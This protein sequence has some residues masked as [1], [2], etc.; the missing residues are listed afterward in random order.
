DV[1]GG[2]GRLRCSHGGS[3]GGSGGLLVQPLADDGDGL[4]R[5]PLGE[6]THFLHRLR[7]HL[8]LHLR[9]V[10]HLAGGA[11][12]RRDGLVV[13]EVGTPAAAV[14]GSASALPPAAIGLSGVMIRR[15]SGRT[16]RS[17]TTRPSSSMTPSSI[18]CMMSSLVNASIDQKPVCSGIRLAGVSAKRRLTI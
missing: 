1:A 8:A 9:D 5:I 2:W 18:A 7:V 17:S 15:T 16:T 6:G 10:D 11:G 13:G 3:I 12:L 4:V 14:P